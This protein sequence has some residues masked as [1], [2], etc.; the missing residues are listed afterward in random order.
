MFIRH[1]SFY[2]FRKNYPV[3]TT[4]AAIHL[5]LFIWMNFLPFGQS[6]QYFG[7]GFNLAV[8]NGE[9]WRLVTPIFLHLGLSHVIFN[10]FSL[11]IFG[12]A[13]EKMLGSVKFLIFYLL[14]GIIA[15]IATFF[16]EQ[17]FYQHLGASGAIYGLLGLYLY[18]VLNRKDLMDRNSGQIVVTIL[19][20]GLIMTFAYSNIN[21]LAHL[22]GLISG[23]AIAPLFLVGVKPYYMQR[24]T[25]TEP[26]EPVF[27]PNRWQQRA[28]KK[29]LMIRIAWIALAVLIIIGI[30]SRLF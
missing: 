24:A 11:V 30:F 19:I 29:Q 9:Y 10:T 8:A 28:K 26:S 21:I 7:V 4:L 22:F 2:S 6:I 14:T 17:P 27:N 13:A 3:I 5:I 25:H 1:E 23:A 15:N 18:I 16:L 12:P 20:I